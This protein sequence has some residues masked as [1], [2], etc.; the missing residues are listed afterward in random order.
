MVWPIVVAWIHYIGIMLFLACLLGEHLVLKPQPSLA[1]ARTLQILDGTYGAAATVV[2]ITGVMRM[3]LE[4]G[5]DY[6]LHDVAFHI[7]VALFVIVALLSIYPT[8]VFI[9]WRGVVRA[10]Q[11]PQ[12]AAGQFGRIQ[13]ILRAEMA[14]LLLAPLFATGMAHGWLTFR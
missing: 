1:E 14:L 8:V 2:L 11:T 10:G 13:M 7:L 6:Y 4:K 12:L 3:F 5:V 9:R